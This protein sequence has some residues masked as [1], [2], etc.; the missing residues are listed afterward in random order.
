MNERSHKWFL[1]AVQSGMD[2][3]VAHFGVE[4][5]DSWENFWKFSIPE[6]T[7]A[8]MKTFGL[9]FPEAAIHRWG[10]LAGP[11][12]WVPQESEEKLLKTDPRYSPFDR[13]VR[14]PRS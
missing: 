11:V 14:P 3:L 12:P 13:G 5:I 1:E 8:K 9:S 6:E 2:Q 7:L 4:V 10:L